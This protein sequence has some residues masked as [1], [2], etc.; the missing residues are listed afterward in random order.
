MSAS[1]PS[2]EGLPNLYLY[3]KTLKL[4]AQKKMRQNGVVSRAR[5][6]TDDVVRS[7]LTEA[8]AL[9]LQLPHPED[10]ELTPDEEF[11]KSVLLRVLF[12]ILDRK[13]Y[14]HFGVNDAVLPGFGGEELA[15][16]IQNQSTADDPTVELLV[17]ESLQDLLATLPNEELRQIAELA[18][19]GA[20][21]DEIAA[22]LQIS[23]ATVYR[24][25]QRIKQHTLD[26]VA[27]NFNTDP[28]HR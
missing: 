17:D 16:S 8:Y 13:V 28:A 25:L 11:V 24:R 26:Y 19:A 12:N 7:T 10:E 22:D 27:V 21:V 2:P 14:K 23:Q 4:L 6:A 15:P 9:N 5:A 1:T 20:A 18:M 3:E